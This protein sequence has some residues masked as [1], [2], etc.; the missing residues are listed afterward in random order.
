MKK[1][2]TVAGM[3]LNECAGGHWLRLTLA[4]VL[5]RPCQRGGPEL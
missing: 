2:R 5:F 3:E 1:P 4:C